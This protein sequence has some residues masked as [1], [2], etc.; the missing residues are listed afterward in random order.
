[1]KEWTSRRGGRVSKRVCAG[2]VFTLL[3]ALSIASCSEDGE[4]NLVSPCSALG[5]KCGG[6]CSD[7]SPCPSGTYCGTDG[8]CTAECTLGGSECKDGKQCNPNGRCVDGLIADGGEY[9][10]PLGDGCI[11]DK[12]VFEKQI[13]TVVLLIDQSGSMTQNFGGGDRWNVLRNALMNSSTG[14]VK[15]LES[16][17]RFGLALYTGNSNNCPDLTEVPVALN[18]FNA[19]DAVYSTAQPEDETPTGESIDQ[20]VTTLGPYAEPGPKVIVLATDG[21]PDTC[22]VPNPQNGQ[23][24]A[25]QAAQAAYAAGI[26]T[27]II[28]VGDQV[29][30]GHLQDMANAGK[31]VAVGGSQNE[32]YYQALDQQALYDA[33]QTIINGVRS[34]VLKLNGTVDPANASKGQVTLDGKPL[35]YEDPD[36]WKLN[37]PSEIELLGA[38]CDLIKEGDHSLTINFPCGVFQPPA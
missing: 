33:F 11:Q 7:L 13:P 3:C 5:D 4:E 23:P 29:S 19:I 12:V 36:G 15:L 20:V 24:E 8:T 32:P 28:S 30:L 26:E 14:I 6:A 34:C 38:A 1:M 25:I 22:A 10:G 16:E 9:D 37:S 27:Y 21:E 31:G 35:G 2:L 17:V 18:N